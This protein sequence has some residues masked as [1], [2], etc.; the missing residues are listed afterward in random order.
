[1]AGPTVVLG[2]AM[3]AAGDGP[4]PARE[5]LVVEPGVCGSSGLFWPTCPS[6]TDSHKRPNLTPHSCGLP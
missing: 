3:W 2:E 4:G 6:E 5:C 1:M